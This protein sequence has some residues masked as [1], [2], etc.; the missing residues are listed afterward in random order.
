[1]GLESSLASYNSWHNVKLKSVTV[2]RKDNCNLLYWSAE[3]DA[4]ES[5]GFKSWKQPPALLEMAPQ[6]FSSVW[7]CTWPRHWGWGD[8]PRTSSGHPTGQGS[9]CRA[10]PSARRR[11]ACSWLCAVPD[12]CWLLKNLFSGWKFIFEF[13]IRSPRSIQCKTLLHRASHATPPKPLRLSHSVS[14]APVL[15]HG[16]YTVGPALPRLGFLAI[17]YTSGRSCPEPL[18]CSVC[19]ALVALA[20]VGLGP[21]LGHTI[22]LGPPCWV[23]FS[24]FP[25][26]THN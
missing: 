11:S 14:L 1:M 4:L 24:F 26:Y 23:S 3:S 25:W 17:A 22:I 9:P 19:V 16:V 20:G 13:R 5:L 8:R 7:G 6:G 12:N 2:F 18:L 15:A 21:H 10:F